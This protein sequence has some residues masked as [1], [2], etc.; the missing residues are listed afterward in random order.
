M[1]LS[2]C[3]RQAV[4]EVA[5][6]AVETADAGTSRFSVKVAV[7]GFVLSG[8]R[9]DMRGGGVID[10]KRRRARL[11]LDLPSGPFPGG[12]RF[13]EDESRLE[14]VF[15]GS[16]VYLRGL[17]TERILPKGR[18]WVR[19][20][21]ERLAKAQGLD[22]GG[23]SQL[24]QWDPRQTLALLGA[25]S[26]QLEEMGTER[27][28]GV[29]TTHYRAT[30]HLSRY[31]GL[32][33][34]AERPRA[35]RAV[36]QL[37]RLLGARELPVDVWVDEA[38]LVRR[39]RQALPLAA[40]GL[41]LTASATVEIEYFDFGTAVAVVVP[42]DRETLPLERV[43]E[44]GLSSPRPLPG[45]AELPRIEPPR[46]GAELPTIDLPPGSV[47]TCDLRPD[48]PPRPYC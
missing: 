26:D 43:W 3:G 7:D 14:E 41:G 46:G 47:N 20:D 18:K 28:R 32:Q 35:K 37:T 48:K 39:S 27:V 45:D 6:A 4:A 23:L 44:G 40:G 33:P 1:A 2:G 25:T 11:V 36:D 15:T 8:G 24:S 22:L 19:I 38:G 21:L 13:T 12:P 42:R 34:P 29:P 17:L 5:E 16:T 31:P 10:A 30:V 9:M